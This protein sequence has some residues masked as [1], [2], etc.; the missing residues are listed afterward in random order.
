VSEKQLAICGCRGVPARH[1]GFETFAEALS[2][3]LVTRGWKV[4]VYCQDAER[5]KV[6]ESVWK[7]I[8]LVHVPEGRSGPLGTI[9]FDWRATNLASKENHTILTLG[10]NTA[11]FNILHRIRGR[12]NIINMDGIEWQREKWSLPVRAWFYL[13]ERLGCWLG[14]RLIADHPEIEAHLATRVSR[15]KITMISY[16]CDEISNIDPAPLASIGLEADKFTLIVGRPQVDNSTLE[17][18]KAFSLKPRG[19]KLAV[20]CPYDPEHDAYHRKVMNSASKEVIFLGGIYDPAIMKALQAHNR[21]YLHGHQVGGTNPSLLE[22]LAAHNAILA[23]GNKFNRW[24]AGE[25]A[26]YFTNENDCATLLEELL[27]D[28]PSLKQLK[29]ASAKRHIENFTWPDVFAAYEK[30]LL[31]PNKTTA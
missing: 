9:L 19:L 25:G 15:N 23:H 24:V 8:R 21:L 1:G 12:T 10:Y 27:E 11:L 26:R 16:G 5:K 20:L 22:A 18:V 28:R 31:G 6:A 14:N 2:L 13:N 17:M 30:V 29:A 3:H 4:T 7:G